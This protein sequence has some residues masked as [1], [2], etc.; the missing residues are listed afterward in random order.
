MSG[1]PSVEAVDKVV[2]RDL[3]RAVVP[4]VGAS[5]VVYAAVTDPGHPTQIALLAVAAGLFAVWAFRP[6]WMPTL[7][8][9]GG[10]LVCVVLAKLSGDLDVGLF[11]VSLLAIVVAGWE[12]SR[13]V[14]AVAGA[15][16]LAT[17]LLIGLL[18][19]GDVDVGIWLA[20]VAFPGL[21]SWLFRRQEE[22]RAQLEESRRRLVARAASDERR[23]IARDVHDLVGHG[24]AA[25][26]LQVAG[27]RHVLRRDP[28]EADV[29]LRAA[30]DAGRRSLTELRATVALLRA[31]GDKAVSA[32]PGLTQ[33]TRLVDDARAAGLA[34]E[35][36]TIGDPGRVEPMV[37]LTLYRVAQEALLNAA[38]HAPAARTAL[39]LDVGDERVELRVHSRLV[40][41]VAGP[42]IG[43]RPGYGLIGMRE[44]ATAVGGEF[45]AGPDAEG[46]LVRCS[47]PLADQPV[48]RVGP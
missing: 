10:V 36:A 41:P 45:H 3:L 34:V 30:E 15:A 40:S 39:T 20:A 17:P 32:V 22:L 19:P 25:V 26:L 46:W 11:L 21:M 6:A 28:D 12:S 2:G 23:R 44:R 31:D 47:V 4:F 27:A 1:E 24:L 35:C 42:A 29:A 37:G 33:L 9:T 43:R 8:L 14:L 7:A 18:N 16:A 5:V 38:R 13:R 48:K